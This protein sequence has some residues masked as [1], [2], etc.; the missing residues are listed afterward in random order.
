MLSPSSRLRCAQCGVVLNTSTKAAWR[1]DVH[2]ALLTNA[3]SFVLSFAAVRMVHA[4]PAARSVPPGGTGDV[5]REL[6]E[7]IRFELEDRYDYQVRVVFDAIRELVTTP[8]KEKTSS[9]LPASRGRSGFFELTMGALRG[10][11]SN[12]PR[13]CSK[14][15]R[16]HS[17]Q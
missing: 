13:R 2:W 1:L 5:G 14:G 15:C 4:P 3:L 9:R 12:K 7:G 6:V 10:R 8:V 17:R 16:Q 11:R